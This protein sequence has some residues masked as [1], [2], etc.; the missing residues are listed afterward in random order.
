[1]IFFMRS[2]GDD[3]LREIEGTLGALSKE[4]RNFMVKNS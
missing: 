1:M 4:N 3:T 2:E